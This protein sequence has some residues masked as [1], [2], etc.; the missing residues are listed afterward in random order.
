MP[1]DVLHELIYLVA[2][3]GAITLST[4]KLKKDLAETKRAVTNKHDIHLR[5]DI[6]RKHDDLVTLIQN[7][8]VRVSKLEKT[9]TIINEKLSRLEHTT[10]Y[11]KTDL[12]EAVNGLKEKYVIYEHSAKRAKDETWR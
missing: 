4:L 10:E 12:W 7:L 1:A 5:D 9:D 8:I 3:V 2:T 11:A 6:D